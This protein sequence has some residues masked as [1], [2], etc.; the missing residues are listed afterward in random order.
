MSVQSRV[1]SGMR[2]LA[3]VTCPHCGIR[4]PA[5]RPPVPDLHW[6]PGTFEWCTPLDSEE[7]LS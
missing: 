6:K 2:L 1:P 4:W 7:T 5:R 3:M